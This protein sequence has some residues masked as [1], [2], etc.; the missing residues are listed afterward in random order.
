M[1][2]NNPMPWLP[3]PA[4]ER[5][6]DGA[7][8]HRLTTLIAPGG[9]GKSA[10][11]NRWAPTVAAVDHALGEDDRTATLLAGRLADVLRLRVPAL[12]SDLSQGLAAPRGPGSDPVEDA[13]A[14][15]SHLGAG[16]QHHLDRD[17]VL[18]LDGLEVLAPG[19]TGAV[20][21]DA[22]LRHAPRRL[23][24]VIAS[25]QPLPFPVDRLR[26]ERAVLEVTGPEL[27]L[28]AEDIEAWERL[29]LGDPTGLARRIATVTGGWTIA[30]LA[31][32]RA[33]QPV[34]PK[35]RA[36]ELAA[37]RPPQD[38]DEPLSQSIELLAP[39]ARRALALAAHLPLVTDDL[40][41]SLGAPPDVL[42]QLVAHGGLLSNDDREP[43]AARLPP[44]VSVVVRRHVGPPESLD[45]DLR[46]AAH[47]FTA[48]GRPDL[49]LQALQAAEAEGALDLLRSQGDQ[50]AARVP[51]AVVDTISRLPASV[52][53]RPWLRRL[54]GMANQVQGRWGLAEQQLEALRDSDAFDAAAAW[55]L[56]LILHLRGGLDDAA[57]V[58]GQGADV[59]TPAVDAVVCRAY[60][61]TVRW[62][63]GDRDGCAQLA[64]QAH[65]E[66]TALG[67]DRALAATHTVLAMLAA[68]DADRR[69]NDAHYQRAVDH[70]EQAGDVLQLIRIR[71]NRAS[72]HLEEGA[73]LDAL[74]EL[75]LA[76]RLAE[77]T[78]FTP[79][80]ALAASNRAEA[81]T[82]LGRL[83]EAARAAGEAV[84][85]WHAMGSELIAYG[86]LQ[87]AEVER[88]RGQ[89]SQAIATLREAILHS[90]R[91]GESHGLMEGL[92]HLADLLCDDDLDLAE[93]TIDRALALGGGLGLVRAQ[94]VAGRI[95]S[96]RGD[97]ETAT[98]LLDQAA[99]H[100][101]QRR[102]QAGL[103][104]VEELRA[105]VAKD[106]L[107]ARVAY[108][109]WRSLG[110]P[111]GSGRARLL[112]L[113]LTRPDDALAQIDRVLDELAA[114]GCHELDARA[115]ALAAELTG[116]AALSIETLGGFR[117]TRHGQVIDRSAWRSNKAR[118][119]LK[120]LVAARGQPIPR[121]RL[122]SELWPQTDANTAGRRLTVLISTLRAVLS[123]GTE[124]TEGTEAV[125]SEPGTLRLDLAQLDI[126]LE[127]FH[128]AV[129]TAATLE[130]VGR[131]ATAR[132]QWRTAVELYRGEFCADEPYADWAEHIREQARA[133]FVQALGRLARSETA[134]GEVDAATRTWLRVLEQDPYDEPAHLALV[135]TLLDARRFGDARRAYD[136][137]VRR[138]VDLGV[139]PTPFPGHQPAR[140][141]GERD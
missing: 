28:S 101:E 109:R 83:E 16:L 34:E 58:Y 48:A 94:V 40:L 105:E 27:A 38:L 127:R 106:P 137:Y 136:T 8:A 134:L 73:L 21:V 24:L 15:A 115:A 88:R 104:A 92:A 103:A 60:G 99:A 100:A 98:E 47:W 13:L 32:L 108:E 57:A 69:A 2:A 128:A 90:E 114:V 45:A 102:D 131:T 36:D 78:G 50:L 10:L 120:L 43:G 18:V 77:L 59:G 116:G 67:D 133:A 118:Q 12:P 25:R 65:E 42:S 140:G 56:G 3:R 55:R 110:D 72:H 14:F 74:A 30:V 1:S 68:M 29:M 80:A 89:R 62:L 61:A 66:A 93:A 64:E 39:E 79:F 49:A 85:A 123:T 33:L 44:A 23:H 63:R 121:E 125:L 96:C 113:E 87:R 117:V 22:L 19:D 37:W 20:L 97:P 4:L 76:E 107:R 82:R 46:R 70:A 130:R 84:A 53:E 95:A 9:A 81:L 26:A 6:L 91:A 112:Q 11:L 51:G 5:R 135:T 138:M 31:A 124:G 86:L 122:A 17:L 71:S 129:D 111:V 54:M 41:R 132:E 35:A 119:L 139:E 7:L 52:A 126:D 141:P 75:E